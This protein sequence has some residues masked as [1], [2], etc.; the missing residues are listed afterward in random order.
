MLTN[1]GSS[2]VVRNRRRDAIP[3]RQRNIPSEDEL[4]ACATLFQTDGEAT[5]IFG[6]VYAAK[7]PSWDLI[8]IGSCGCLEARERSLSGANVPYPFKMI[9]SFPALNPRSLEREIHLLFDEQ[10]PHLETSENSTLKKEF[11]MIEEPDII[12]FFA[13]KAKSSVE[14]MKVI[15]IANFTKDL[16]QDNFSQYENFC[17]YMECSGSMLSKAE[18]PAWMRSAATL[19]ELLNA[20]ERA[21]RATASSG[22]APPPSSSPCE[23]RAGTPASSAGTASGTFDPLQLPAA[24]VA[25]CNFDAEAFARRI[26]F[27]H[28]AP[29]PI[30]PPEMHAGGQTQGV[31]GGG[32]CRDRALPE[33]RIR[34]PRGLNAARAHPRPVSHPLSRPPK[35]AAA[36]PPPSHPQ[37]LPAGA[38]GKTVFKAV[39]SG[40]SAEQKADNF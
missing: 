2:H 14:S 32:G 7:N 36:P 30:Y 18:R 8:K 31:R 10:R 20:H 34:R 21:R 3:A 24:L 22:G 13:E 23:S 38:G 40:L 33:S 19:R 35:P 26:A 25:A 27:W 12:K 16:S 4:K 11:F 1:K 29:E 5:E 17:N 39:Y 6:H 9:A 28:Q 15:D 37:A